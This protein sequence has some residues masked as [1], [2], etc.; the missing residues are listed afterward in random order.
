MK[1]K[2]QNDPRVE[3]LVAELRKQSTSFAELWIPPICARTKT[4]PGL[5][6]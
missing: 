2:Y 6:E 5:T 3:G 4:G 1:P